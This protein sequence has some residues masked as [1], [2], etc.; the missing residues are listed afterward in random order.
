MGIARRGSGILVYHCSCTRQGP[1]LGR[2][3]Q[4]ERGGRHCPLED[5]GYP[6]SADA[7]APSNP[8]AILVDCD[9]NI[10]QYWY[11]AFSR[12]W[13]GRYRAAQAPSSTRRS[14]TLYRFTSR[15]VRRLVRV[16]CQTSLKR[17]GLLHSEL[18]SDFYLRNAP[19]ERGPRSASTI[20]GAS[21][22][23]GRHF[24]ARIANAHTREA[25]VRDVWRFCRWCEGQG[26]GLRELVL[27]SVAA[28][29]EHLGGSLSVASI[30][31]QASAIRHWLDYLTECG[32]LPLNPARSVR[33]PRL[34][35]K[36]PGLTREPVRLCFERPLGRVAAPATPASS[37]PGHSRRP[38]SGTS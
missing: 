16:R 8:E 25:Y 35:S 26:I 28:Y 10:P 1:G 22:F 38:P 33:T 18:G 32:A 21:A 13:L 37:R 27:T 34:A 7:S 30:K 11:T 36:P 15:R 17:V 3:T 24:A 20:R 14:L 6:V 31:Q 5:A 29:F 4:R 2:L 9:M 19:C 23:A 12:G